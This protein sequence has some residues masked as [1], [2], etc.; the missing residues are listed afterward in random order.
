MRIIFLSPGSGGQFYCENCIRDAGL[1]RGLRAAGADALSVPMYLPAGVEHA[2]IT[3][4]PIFFGGVNVY[5]QQK[6]GLFRKTPRWL[7]ALLDSQSLLAKV[8]RRAGMTNAKELGETTLSMLAGRDGRQVKELDRL[9]DWLILP[10][11]RPDVVIFSNAL[12]IGL[13]SEVKRRL[14]CKTMCLLQDEDGFVDGLGEPWTGRV[15]DMIGQRAADIDQFVAVSGYYRDAMCRRLGLA[16]DR[17]EVVYGGLDLSRYVAGTAWQ[18]GTIGFLS[19]MCYDN[20]LDILIEAAGILQRQPAADIRLILCGGQT[21]ADEQFIAGVK[22]R[23]AELGLSGRVEFRSD[24]S[25]E[26]RRQFLQDISILCVPHRHPVAYG[27]SVLEAMAAGAAFAAP[28][29]GVFEEYLRMSEGGVLYAPNNAKSLAEALRPLVS[30]AAYAA[31]LGQ[32]G[33]NAAQSHFQLQTNVLNL[34]T[35][36]RKVIG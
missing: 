22:R 34:L 27:L 32:H 30:D 14:G 6:F 21:S 24:F 12:L 9:I 31:A 28:R 19:H 26:A 8:S 3:Q 36:I 20:G 16:A 11:N 33:R 7:D 1:L 5:L 17:I 23:I 10:E 29:Q 15:W 18:A 4:S 35:I 13:A 25:P 2:G